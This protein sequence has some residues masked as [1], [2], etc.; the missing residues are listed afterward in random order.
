GSAAAPTRC[1]ASTSR[2]V[3][4]DLR[5]FG[6]LAS[7]RWTH[8]LLRRR[9]RVSAAQVR[10][11][12]PSAGLHNVH[13]AN[14]GLDRWR[15][16][17]G[18]R[19]RPPAPCDAVVPLDLDAGEDPGPQEHRT[20]SGADV[21]GGTEAD[22]LVAQRA[23][24]H[25]DVEARPKED[26]EAPREIPTEAQAQRVD[27]RV[28]VA[29]ER[30]LGNVRNEELRLE[31]M[32][33]QPPE[34]QVQAQTGA[35]GPDESVVARAARAQTRKD[36]RMDGP[37][38]GLQGKMRDREVGTP[39]SD[40]E[41]A[42]ADEVEQAHRDLARGS[43]VDQPNLGAGGAS[44]EVDHAH[45]VATGLLGQGHGGDLGAFGLSRGGQAD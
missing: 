10:R 34:L 42:V 43:D 18:R 15:A 13:Y 17:S 9:R 21:D 38:A 29:V 5:A 1:S 22:L 12:V 39:G 16:R 8:G 41:S 26:G 11:P 3:P 40:A 33:A 14:Q 20:G 28:I 37:A 32:D 31:E 7:D 36:D 23:L 4:S 45:L 6:S 44:R 25:G 27:E 24:L 35:E 30:T 19:D 2:S